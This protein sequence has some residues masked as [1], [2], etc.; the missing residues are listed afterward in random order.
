[1][2]PDRTVWRSSAFRFP[3]PACRLP[4]AAFLLFAV[5]CDFQ[6]DTERALMASR[7]SE[8]NRREVDRERAAG[9]MDEQAAIALVTSS[10]TPDGD[11]MTNWL[12]AQKHTLKGQVMFPQWSAVRRGRVKYEVRHTFTFINEQNRILKTGYSWDVDGMLRTV[13]PPREINSGE[14]P[15]E[16]PSSETLQDRRVYAAEAALE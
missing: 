16:T 14:T 4:L 3:L 5:S 8:L 15:Q 9:L 10:V 1:M 12:S 2:N 13:G 7:E 11:R 6:S